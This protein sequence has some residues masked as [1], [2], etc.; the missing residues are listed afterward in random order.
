M[1]AGL[2][3]VSVVE[4]VFQFHFASQHVFG[5]Y[6]EV[7]PLFQLREK[8]GTFLLAAVLLKVLV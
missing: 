1:T 5:K 3:Q 8:E 4:V 2:R 6:L 7:Q